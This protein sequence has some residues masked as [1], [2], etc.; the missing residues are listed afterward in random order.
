MPRAA[1]M[2]AAGHSVR[3]THALLGSTTTAVTAAGSAQND[4]AQLTADHSLITT[5]TDGQGVILPALTFGDLV[6]VS[7]GTAV[8][9]FVY[10]VT[11]GKF[12]GQAA[13]AALE[14]PPAHAALFIALNATDCNVIY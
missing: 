8:N 10:P 13:N 4:A 3:D 7:N 1:F 2:I 5:C 9:A 6:S 14:L 11:G 12:N